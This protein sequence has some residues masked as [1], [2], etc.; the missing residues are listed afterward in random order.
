MPIPIY[1]LFKKYSIEVK[2][3]LEAIFHIPRLDGTNARVNVVYATPERAIAKYVAPLRNKATDIPIIGF[4]LSSMNYQPEKSSIGENLET[5]YDKDNNAA[6]RLRPLQTY[7]L[8][9]SVNIWTRLQH[10]MDLVLYQLATQFL[11]MRWLAIDSSIDYKN[12]DTL[13][14]MENGPRQGRDWDSVSNEFI[15]RPGQWFPL[16]LESMNDVSELEPGDASDRLIRY[17]VNL[18]CDRAFLPV[19]GYEYKA[20]K[21]ININTLTDWYQEGVGI[22]AITQSD[23]NFLMGNDD[24]WAGEVANYSDLPTWDIAVASLSD[25]PATGNSDGDVALVRATRNL[26]IWNAA[27]TKWQLHVE[28]GTIYRVTNDTLFDD[29]GEPYIWNINDITFYKQ[30]VSTLNDLPLTGN[31]DNDIRYVHAESKYYIWNSNDS[32]W[33]EYS[34]WV[35]YRYY[36]RD[37]VA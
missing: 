7:Q 27:E 3:W 24:N 6:K 29:D 26:H 9:Y 1:F 8:T 20:I 23:F 18:L 33:E 21:S 5:I 17:D 31:I 15:K 28:P 11:P 10:D 36:L 37:F 4:Y 30:A 32:E 14:T 16:I 22:Y 35:K 25:L 12:Y 2:R 13:Q 34:K 19:G